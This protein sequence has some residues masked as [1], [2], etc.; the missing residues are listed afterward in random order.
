MK[1]VAIY[2]IGIVLST[3][4]AYA[5]DYAT[6]FRDLQQQFE[7]RT[8]T[9]PTNIK[10]YLE[11]YPYTPYSD[12]IYLM[13]G[14][15]YAEKEKYKQATKSFSK[16]NAK[17]L[18]RESQPMLHFYWGYALMKLEE[19]EKA[20]SYLLRVKQKES[21]YTPHAR[22]YAGYCYYCTKDFQ[23]ALAE[24]LAVQHLAGYQQIVPYYIIQIDYAQGDYDAVYTKANQLLDTFPDNKHNYELHRMLGEMYFQDSA[25]QESIHH[26]EAYQRLTIEQERE[27]LRNDIYL[28][29][30][31]NYKEGKYQ[32]AIQQLKTVKEQKDSISESTYLH[33][34]HCYLRVGDEEKAKLSYAA[35]MRINLNS[36]VREEAMYNYVQ[37]TYLQGSALGD[38]I[39]AFQDFL[40]EYPNTKYASNVYALMADMYMNSKNYKEDYEA[41]AEIKQ[42]DGKMQETM[43]FLRYQLGMDAFLRGNMKEAAEWMTQVIK[44]E[45]KSSVYKT[46]AYYV[47]AESRYRMLQY[48]TCIEDVEAFTKQTNATKSKNY[49]SSLYLKGYALFN[50]QLLKQ[51]EYIFRQYLSQADS[52]QTLFTDALN[53]LGDCLF[54]SRQFDDAIATYERVVRL[55]NYATDYA[56]FQQGYALGL[57]HRYPE[58]IQKMEQLSSRYPRS[59]YAD[60]A[61]YETARAHLQLDQN[62]QAIKV[63]TRILGQYPNSNKAAKSALELSMTYRTLKQ[64]DKAIQAYKNTIEKYAG[65]EE[66]YAALEGLEQVYVETNNIN[67]YLAYTKTLNKINMQTSTQEDSLVYVTAELQY[68]MGNYEEAA[69]GMTTYI[70]SFCPGGRY[71]VTAQYYAANSF[72]QLREYDA[73]KEQY[74]AL[75]EIEGNQY[76]EEAC[77]R[78]AEIAYDKEEYS[79]AAYYFQQM[80][81]VASSSTMRI[82]AQ[83]G[84]LRCNQHEGNI[85]AVIAAATQLLEQEQLTD[86]I[87]QEALYYRAKA[88]LSNQQYGLAIVDL[89]PLSKEVRT[90]IGAEAKYLL[91][92][93][94]FQLG[95]IELSEEEIMS[96]T[97]MQTAQQYWLAKSLILLSDINV[98]RN[99]IFQAKQYLLALQSNY[100]QSDDIPTIIAEKL[101]EIEELETIDE[102][103]STELEENTL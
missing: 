25:Y 60:D 70:T 35:A 46:E 13:E 12:E 32:E 62:E 64:Y 31:A 71:C 63:Y 92:N 89:T 30:V 22:Y 93:A 90:P 68:I 77:M 81:R 38:N 2:I 6:D 100:H 84:I 1:R 11:Q 57:L 29:G 75:A 18:S 79:T 34:G 74:S 80:L 85:E 78:V 91:A 4:V 69:A 21:L 33:L 10:T 103:P 5:Q 3:A 61:L 42:P 17:N 20:L 41:L 65:S 87:R 101:Q 94:Y 23:S 73:A 37:I 58:K 67:D 39:T 48:P 54:N 7:E 45:K 76:M 95:S 19:Y 59:D 43:Q 66:A 53:R 96:F 88:H 51:A 56:L 102:Q 15:L 98:Q 27:A 50:Q 83:I 36:K 9:T 47:R 97:Q 82:T 24:F 16:I 55:G 14:V 86:N 72:Y 52:T 40:R 26:L 49:V 99:D 28:L 8:K 44:N